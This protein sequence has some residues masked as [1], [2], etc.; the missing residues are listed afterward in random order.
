M[1]LL[2]GVGFSFEGI[3]RLLDSALSGEI[4]LFRGGETSLW[5][6][7]IDLLKLRF[8]RLRVE[9]ETLRLRV[10]I[11]SVFGV[12]RTETATIGSHLLPLILD[13]VLI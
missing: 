3:C 1:L 7:Q 2:L 4:D 13:V 5:C 12:K 11:F 6:H 10:F 8:S 9:A